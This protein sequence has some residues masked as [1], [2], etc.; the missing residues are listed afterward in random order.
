MTVSWYGKLPSTGDFVSRRLDAVQLA[1]LDAWLA[2]LMQN[3]QQRR[4]DDW[5]PAYLASPSWRFLWMPEALPLPWQGRA[6]VGVL[7]PSVDRAG[8]YYPLLMLHALDTM[9]WHASEREALWS[10]LQQLDDIAAGALHDDWTIDALETS[11]AAL[12][13]PPSS[14]QTLPT[15]GHGRQS[16]RRLDLGGQSPESRLALEAAAYWV[17]MARDRCYWCG[18]VEGSVTL[19]VSNGFDDEDLAGALLGGA[20]A[21]LE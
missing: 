4:S 13:E 18:A 15:L 16:L 21:R 19:L 5:L 10:W 2:S 6:W 17:H 12:G 14:E 9:P 11:L 8:R 1:S 20:P 7:M 3:L